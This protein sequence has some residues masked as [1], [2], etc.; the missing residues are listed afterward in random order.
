VTEKPVF[1]GSEAILFGIV[2]EPWQGEKRRGAVILLN[3]GGSYHVG[4]S[5]MYVPLAGDGLGAVT[6]C[7]EMDY[8]GLGESSV[9]PGQPWNDMFPPAALT[10]IRA[11]IE[12]LKK[13]HGI[14]KFP[15]PDCAPALTTHYAPLSRPCRSLAY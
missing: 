13:H 15:S 7:C 1:F 11:G 4:A 6:L 8:A 9:R 2:T 5:R 12:L 3:A 10:D 14:R